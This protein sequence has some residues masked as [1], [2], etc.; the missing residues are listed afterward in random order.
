VSQQTK[1]TRL[2]I[3]DC[4]GVLVDSEPI[5]NR[6]F[7]QAL[8]ELGLHLSETQ[9]FDYFIG[10]SMAYCLTVVERLLGRSAPENFL[11]DLQARTFAAFAKELRP[12]PHIEQ[13]LDEITVPCCV[14]SSGDHAKMRTTLGITG[15]L[16]RFEGR[17]FSV[18]QVAHAKPAPDV[19]LYAAEQ[20]GVQPNACV[21][22]EDTP[23]GV[24]AGAAA[25]MTVLGYCA[26][27]SA[28]KLRAAGAHI[29]FDDMRRLPQLLN[30][31]G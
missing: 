25:G 11:D 17:L 10:R 5:A 7:A 16:H 3:F 14:A 9:M 21:V 6:V 8:A 1:Q 30:L 26:H 28:T 31:Q 23:P 4:D 15:L 12:M 13:A 27:T 2:V 20:M 24:Q 29:V 19:Y 18:T 22:I